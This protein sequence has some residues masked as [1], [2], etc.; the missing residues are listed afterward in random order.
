M[1]ARSTGIKAPNPEAHWF[2]ES[3][4][5]SSCKTAFLI[6]NS[7]RSTG[8]KISKIKLGSISKC[9]NQSKFTSKTTLQCNPRTH[10]PLKLFSSLRSTNRSWNWSMKSCISLIIS[11]FGLKMKNLSSFHLSFICVWLI[12]LGIWWVR[13]IRIVSCFSCLLLI[14]WLILSIIR[15]RR[16]LFIFSIRFWWWIL[17]LLWK[18]ALIIYSIWNLSIISFF[19]DVTNKQSKVKSFEYPACSISNSS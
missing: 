13:K 2:P 12:R 14:R 1:T 4:V 10:Q 5:K 18:N 9:K 3:S 17:Q 6:K 11:L 16:V 8:N 7:A 15:G 19:V